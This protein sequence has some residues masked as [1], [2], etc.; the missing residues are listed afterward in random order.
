[1]HFYAFLQQMNASTYRLSGHLLVQEPLVV[2]VCSKMDEIEQEFK[3]IRSSASSKISQ[4]SR[5]LKITEGLTPGESWELRAALLNF[6]HRMIDC[7]GAAFHRR[8]VWPY[9]KRHS[10]ALGCLF[11]ES[12]VVTLDARTMCKF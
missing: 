8:I 9:S 10:N 2:L 5:D 7:A 4:L 6:I 1:M 12:L 11:V 3:D